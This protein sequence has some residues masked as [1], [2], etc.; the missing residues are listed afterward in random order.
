MWPGCILPKGEL[1][2]RC[3]RSLQKSTM[4]SASEEQGRARSSKAASSQ[5]I[6]PGPLG[7]KNTTRLHKTKAEI[8]TVGPRPKAGLAPARTEAKRKLSKRSSNCSRVLAK[9]TS[10][11]RK[12]LPRPAKE[13]SEKIR[14]AL[15]FSSNRGRGSEAADVRS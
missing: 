4:N 5:G 2:R 13:A 15:S 6:L 9:R 8:H 11:N 3:Q 14:N 12:E 7:Q 1:A 10:P